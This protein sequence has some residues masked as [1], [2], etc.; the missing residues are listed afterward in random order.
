MRMESIR[1]VA[2][3]LAVALSACG[4]GGGVSDEPATTE[5]TARLGESIGVADAIDRTREVADLA[6]QR[7]DTIDQLAPSP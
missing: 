4:G 1:T 5:T 2:V 7:Y 3:S 6:E